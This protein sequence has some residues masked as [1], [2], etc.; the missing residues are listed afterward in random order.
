MPAEQVGIVGYVVFPTYQVLLAS[1][2]LAY[3]PLS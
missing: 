3:P 2:Q 1:F